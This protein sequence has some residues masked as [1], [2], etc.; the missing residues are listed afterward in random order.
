MLYFSKTLKDPSSLVIHN[1][2]YKIDESKKKVSRTVDYGAK[3]SFGGMERQTIHFES[4]FR[5]MFLKVEGKD[6][7]HI[8]YSN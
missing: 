6:V 5:G 4:G 7:D 3:N 2:S 1:E 8:L